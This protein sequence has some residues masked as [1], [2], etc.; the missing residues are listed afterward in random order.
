MFLKVC[1]IYH[2]YTDS[3]TPT[4]KLELL[5]G[6]ASASFVGGAVLACFLMTVCQIVVHR[7]CLKKNVIE[8]KDNVAYETVK[9]Q[10]NN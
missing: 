5:I 4:V 1:L 8:V 7:C 10:P 2:I 6:L 9:I 3:V